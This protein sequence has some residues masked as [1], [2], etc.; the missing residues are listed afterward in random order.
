MAAIEVKI[1]C[2]VQTK[3]LKGLIEFSKEH[4][5]KRSIV[6]SLETKKRLINASGVKILIYPIK[7]F[8]EELWNGKIF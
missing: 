1:S 2:L 6:I 3:E 5:P 7:N 8:L 4:N